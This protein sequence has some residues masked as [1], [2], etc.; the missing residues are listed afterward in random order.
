MLASTF[1]HQSPQEKSWTHPMIQIRM[2]QQNV[3]TDLASENEQKRKKK[4][5]GK[6]FQL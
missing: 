4:F 2:C 3:E 5:S 6:T 1:N